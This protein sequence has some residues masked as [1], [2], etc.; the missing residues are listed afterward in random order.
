MRQLIPRGLHFANIHFLG[1][2]GP[3]IRA[4]QGYSGAPLSWLYCPWLIWCKKL[5]FSPETQ[6]EK[7]KNVFLHASTWS[8]RISWKTRLNCS[9]LLQAVSCICKQ[10]AF[11]SAS[12][13]RLLLLRYNIQHAS[14]ERCWDVFVAAQR[15][16]KSWVLTYERSRNSMRASSATKLSCWKFEGTLSNIDT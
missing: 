11:N 13:T 12:S 2:L 3:W 7:L 16:S 4:P 8:T 14:V 1:R 10:E 5:Q 6:S 9:F 15:R